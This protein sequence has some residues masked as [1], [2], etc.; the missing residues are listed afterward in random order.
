MESVGG[1]FR[2]HF[3][4]SVTI[5]IAEKIDV[6]DMVGLTIATN[7]AG[8]F[9][10]FIGFSFQCLPPSKALVDGQKALYIKLRLR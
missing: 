9:S 8:K 3:I 1:K 2:T 4:G 5:E 7:H 10:H 6:R